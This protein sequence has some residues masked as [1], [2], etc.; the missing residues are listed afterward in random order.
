MFLRIE[1]WRIWWKVNRFG[2]AVSCNP[3]SDLTASMPAA[4][5]PDDDQ[6]PAS[7]ELADSLQYLSRD[8]HV[9]LVSQIGVLFTSFQVQEA[10]EVLSSSGTVGLNDRW[11]FAFGQ[12]HFLDC[13][14]A[15]EHHLVFTENDCIGVGPMLCKQWLRLFDPGFLSFRVSFFVCLAWAMPCEVGLTKQEPLAGLRFVAFAELL[16]DIQSKQVGCPMLNLTTGYDILWLFGFECNDDLLFLG[17]SQYPIAI[18]FPVILEDCAA[19]FGE[20]TAQAF[21]MLLGVAGHRYI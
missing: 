9:L 7:V 13:G 4:V 14:S 3:L 21:G 2:I 18:V 16:K 11:V 8:T 15:G 6:Q 1:L 10:V 17:S 5:I 12:P 19:V 20:A